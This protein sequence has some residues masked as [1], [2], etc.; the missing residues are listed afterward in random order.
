M[1]GV[2]RHARNVHLAFAQHL[3]QVTAKGVRPHLADKGGLRAEFC[4]GNRQISRRA[5]G[6]CGKLRDAA[7]VA[8]GL[9]QID[10]NFADG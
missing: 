9:G 4:G 10:Q 8:A 3:G 2:D 1:L 5:A 7:P 6:V